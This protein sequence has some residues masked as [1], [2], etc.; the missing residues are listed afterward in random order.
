MRITRS[1]TLSITGGII[2]LLMI[3]FIVPSTVAI[4]KLYANDGVWEDTSYNISNITCVNDV[5][6]KNHQIVLKPGN[7]EQIKYNFLTQ[8]NHLAY[9][10]SPFF[11]SRLF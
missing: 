7:S 2:I 11:F 4:P 5:E 9:S 10:Y 6:V 3:G 8:D 1:M